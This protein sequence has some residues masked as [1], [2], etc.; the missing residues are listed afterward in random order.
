MKGIRT[1]KDKQWKAPSFFNLDKP[2]LEEYLVAF[3][4]TDGLLIDNEVF[5]ESIL[6]PSLESESYRTLIA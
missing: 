2:K 6:N 5:P 3:E 1:S 4:Q